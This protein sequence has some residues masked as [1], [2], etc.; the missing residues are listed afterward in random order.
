MSTF[1]FAGTYT[2][3]SKTEHRDEGIYAYRFDAENGKLVLSAASH[4]GWNPSFVRVHPNR[5][6]LYATNESSEGRVSSLAVNPSTGALTLINSQ[7]TRGAAP[8]YIS[9]DPHGKFIL[10]SNYSSGSL[11]VFPIAEDGHLEPMSSFI[12]HI[13]TGFN[14]Q[15]Q[16]R[17]HAHSIGFDLSGNFVLA[18]DLGIDRVLVYRL[19]SATGELALGEL[20]GAAMR[21]GAGPRHFACHPNGKVIY[22][23]NELDS[24]VTA[25]VW[26]GG[27]GFLAPIQ[28]L[29]TLAEGYSGDNSVADIHLSPDAHRL[30]V[31]N[32][33]D[34]SLAVYE[35]DENGAL[36]QLAIVDCG[37][38]WPR[39]FAIDPSGK[40]LLVANQYSENIVVFKLD[41]QGIPVQSGEV[42]PVPSPVCLDFVEF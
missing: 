30:Y 7:P 21:P 27:K 12:E 34:N 10:V 3:K 8:C 15:R 35:V 17:A 38:N 33:G 20:W 16:E 36:E 19:N 22:V 31:S 32:R 13:G 28:N 9:F 4:A 14:I 25:C 41:A 18:A 5:R 24:T 42:I 26:D 37:G 23:A 39:N 2:Q 11:A 6:F 29:P 1:V 40:W